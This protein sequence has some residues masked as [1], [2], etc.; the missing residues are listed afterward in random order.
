MMSLKL[1]EWRKK[2]SKKVRD[3]LSFVFNPEDNGG[4]SLT[5]T[6]QF[7]NNGDPGEVYM[8]QE[9]SLQSYCNSASINLVGVQVTPDSL[10]ELANLL[11][12][13]LVEATN[14]C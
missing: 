7:F 8:N 13:A 14:N 1:M 2:M 9:L 4:E 10:R 6:T 3:N 11:D 12:K 5:L